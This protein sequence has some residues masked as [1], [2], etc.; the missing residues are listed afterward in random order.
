MGCG[1]SPVS[2]N[3]ALGYARMR[4]AGHASRPRWSQPPSNPSAMQT[5]P[6][7]KKP[8]NNRGRPHGSKARRV[9]MAR[10]QPMRPRDQDFGGRKEAVLST[11]CEAGITSRRRQTSCRPQGTQPGCRRSWTDDEVFRMSS[12]LRYHRGVGVVAPSQASILG[13]STGGLPRVGP[14]PRASRV[15]AAVGNRSPVAPGERAVSR[16]PT[17]AGS[18]LGPRSDSILWIA[19]F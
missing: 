16:W 2:F 18:C 9:G 15:S 13:C 12:P 4:A 5:A 10:N 8:R 7:D 3:L 17:G 1:A 11:S 14:G 6:V 19:R